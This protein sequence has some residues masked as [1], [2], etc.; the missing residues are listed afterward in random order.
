MLQT[1]V[2][3]LSTTDSSNSLDFSAPGLA[4]VSLGAVGTRIYTGTITPHNNIYRL[5]GGSGT[6]TVGTV[7]TGTGASTVISTNGTATTS[8][9][10]LNQQNTYD[11]GTTLDS[12]VLTIAASSSPANNDPITSGPV[13]TGILTLNGGTLAN[14]AAVRNISNPIV[15]NGTTSVLSNSTSNILSLNGPITGTGTILATHSSAS[16]I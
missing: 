3:A 4:G 12:G 2:V 5:G 14:D 1:G 10:I 6:L 15:V 13:G 16:T 7:L 8:T 11:G 9:V